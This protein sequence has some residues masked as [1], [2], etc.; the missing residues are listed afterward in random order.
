MVPGLGVVG[1][2]ISAG[3]G[4]VAAL[5]PAVDKINFK[6]AGNDIKKGANKIKNAFKKAF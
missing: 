3:A 4:A 6:K 2:A 5:T 1:G